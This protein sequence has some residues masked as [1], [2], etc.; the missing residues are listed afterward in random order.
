[1]YCWEQGFLL[2]GWEGPAST[3]LRSCTHVP[4]VKYLKKAGHALSPTPRPVGQVPHVVKLT[5]EG[6]HRIPALLAGEAHEGSQPATQC[7]PPSPLPLLRFQSVLRRHM[8]EDHA[9]YLG[10]F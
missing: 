7:P 3:A 5:F 9:V 2:E 8:G 1:M 6:L 4:S 10:H